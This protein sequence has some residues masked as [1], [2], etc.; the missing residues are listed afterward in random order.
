VRYLPTEET[1][2]R[3]RPEDDA[4]TVAIEKIGDTWIITTVGGATAYTDHD[5]ALDAFDIALAS[6]PP[7]R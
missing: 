5:A 7:E 2:Y 4:P 6:L 3:T 1:I